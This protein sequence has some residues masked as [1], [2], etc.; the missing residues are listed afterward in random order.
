MSNSLEAFV[1]FNNGDKKRKIVKALYLK[2]VS[3]KGSK[4]KSYLKII[5]VIS[6]IKHVEIYIT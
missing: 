2:Y 4:S 6:S 1:L 5:V 3:Q